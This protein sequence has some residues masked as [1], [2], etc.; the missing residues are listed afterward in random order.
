MLIF[1]PLAPLL[2]TAVLA[3]TVAL[4]RWLDRKD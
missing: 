3:A 4:E 1:V 2:L